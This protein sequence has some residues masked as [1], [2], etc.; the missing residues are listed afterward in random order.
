MQ[1]VA[2]TMFK[3]ASFV[4]KEVLAK[5]ER[6]KKKICKEL[7]TQCLREQGL[8]REKERRRKYQHN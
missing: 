5:K 2:N 4:E 1:G 8:S 7:Q 6:K 3:R